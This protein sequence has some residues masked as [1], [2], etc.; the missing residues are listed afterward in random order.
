M[1]FTEWKG[2]SVLSGGSFDY[3]CY[4]DVPELMNSSSIANLESMVQH[5]Q[6]YG[7]EDIARDTQRLIEYIQSASI[8]IEVLS[9]NLNDVFHAV[10]WH[11]S[12]DISRET[13]IERLENYRNGG[14][15]V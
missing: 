15:N 2:V 10:E 12:G 14:A 6:E 7:Y 1:D 11:E 8:R 3:L 4:K 13:M 5:L 9:E